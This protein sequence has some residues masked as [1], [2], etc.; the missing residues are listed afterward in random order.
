MIKNYLKTAIRTLFRNR[1]HTMINMVGLALGITCSLVLFL[2]ADHA[3]SYD[4]FQENKERI[5]RIVHSARGQGG[6]IDYTPGVPI[7]LPDAI[8]EDFPEFEKV[9]LTSDLHD[10]KLFT[11]NPDA[12]QPQHFE[13]TQKRLVY[14]EPQYFDIFT[15]QWIAG[16]KATALS[17]P[18]SIV[19]TQTIADMLFPD[20]DALG[21]VI[22]FN[23]DYQLKVTGVIKDLPETTDMPFD[24]YVSLETIR[25]E[26]K[27]SGWNSISSNDQCYVLL[28]G[29]DNPDT[30]K[31]RLASFEKKYFGEGSDNPK[32]FELQPMSD[33]H[34]N[35]HWSNYSYNTISSDQITLMHVVAIFLLV[36]ACINFINLS[37]AV[38]VKRSREVGVRK[39]LGGTKKQLIFQFM[40]E[41]FGIVLISLIVALGL[42]ELMLIY[43]NPFLE[44]ELSI[45]L[46][47]IGFLAQLALGTVLITILSGFYPALVL[48]RF[49]PALALKNLINYKHSG[50]VSLRKGLVIFQFFISQFFIIGTIITISQM[51]FLKSADLGYT[52]EALINLRIPENDNQ[53]KKTLK[54]ELN[55]IAGVEKVS[56]QFS[57]PSSGSVSVSNFTF[58]DNPEDFYTSM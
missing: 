16:N 1:L 21:A 52:S 6:E 51:H 14:T 56:L 44:V 7:P 10:D 54:N 40:A 37:T 15:T 50:G 55:R 32:T 58:E 48:S 43:L 24:M 53:K 34:F 17:Q 19:L 57:N 35:E 28:A 12:D 39:V 42:A 8:R 20:K 49:Q 26:I 11:I 36:T 45:E 29:K 27:E 9:V 31:S 18:N 23:K 38:A 33:L 41:S 47:D 30:Y 3:L 22:L 4:D 25:E 46:T 5:Y 2:L 13:L